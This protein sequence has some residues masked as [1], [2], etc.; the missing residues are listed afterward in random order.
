[1]V[2]EIVEPLTVRSGRWVSNFVEHGQHEATELESKHSENSIS[3]AVQQKHRDDKTPNNFSHYHK[4]LRHTSQ[5]CSTGTS[6][7]YGYQQ[8]SSPH[9][10]ENAPRQSATTFLPPRMQGAGHQILPNYRKHN[11]YLLVRPRVAL[12]NTNLLTVANKEPHHL[13]SRIA[14]PPVS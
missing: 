7:I 3:V 14:G 12:A 1:M 2:R 10:E 13:L 4:S 11:A 9:D 5:F 6:S 8:N